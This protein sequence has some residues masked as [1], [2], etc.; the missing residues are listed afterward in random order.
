ML[1]VVLVPYYYVS[2]GEEKYTIHD[3][4]KISLLK[5]H[6]FPLYPKNVQDQLHLPATWRDI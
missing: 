1:W 6:P 4:A 5:I 3:F 2:S